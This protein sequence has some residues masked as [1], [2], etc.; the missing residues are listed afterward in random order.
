M[1][2]PSIK[3][4]LAEVGA[5]VECWSID[6]I[7]SSVCKSQQPGYLISS[8]GVAAHGKLVA[9]ILSLLTNR[10]RGAEDPFFSHLDPQ[11]TLY[12]IR[13]HYQEG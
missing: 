4:G 5:K 13:V 8:L 1:T 2:S 11:Y 9:P 3:S 6:K 7:N 10:Q 12:P